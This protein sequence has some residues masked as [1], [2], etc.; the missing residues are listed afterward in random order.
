MNL[1]TVWWIHFVYV[2][3]RLADQNIP[4]G[5]HTSLLMISS[6][7]TQ[8]W[9]HMLQGRSQPL[10]A[11]GQGISRILI[12]PQTHAFRHGIEFLESKAGHK[13]ISSKN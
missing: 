12:D 3:E 9:W 6:L 4:C 8:R 5:N 13:E 11:R 10:S 2:T 7:S 1:S